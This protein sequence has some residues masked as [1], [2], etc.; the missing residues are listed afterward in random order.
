M[1][2]G[3]RFVYFEVVSGVLLFGGVAIGEMRVYFFFQGKKGVAIRGC[4]YSGNESVYFSGQKVQ[5]LIIFTC[6][7]WFIY[8]NI[9]QF[10]DMYILSYT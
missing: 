6:T 5:F 10:S 8:V 1:L 4:C 2:F 9:L 3:K 7:F